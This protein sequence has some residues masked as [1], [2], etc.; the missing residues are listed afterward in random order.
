MKAH[1]TLIGMS[2]VGKTSIGKLLAPK[3][4]YQFLDIDEEISQTAGMP[5]HKVVESVGESQFLELESA[6]ILNLQLAAPTIISTGGS[7]IYK[8]EA[9]QWLKENSRILYLSD[10]SQNIQARIPNL[11]SRGIIGLKHR[12]FA[13]LHE[14]RASLY[15]KWA[16][17][18]VI[19]P[20][21]FELK[22]ATQKIYQELTHPKHPYSLS[23]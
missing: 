12:T 13:Q 10:T 11:E 22:L 5:L 15:R 6:T 14:E 21:P 23:S 9:M 8:Q 16:D 4:K 19:L 1:I 2:G 18:T 7:I 17:I 20:V 3:I